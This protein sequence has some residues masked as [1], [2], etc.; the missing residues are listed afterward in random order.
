MK[1]VGKVVE[2]LQY[3]FI[4]YPCSIPLSLHYTTV[5]KKSQSFSESMHSKDTTSIYHQRFFLVHKGATCLGY[6]ALNLF[7]R[8]LRDF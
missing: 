3:E 8:P 6:V 7:K 4:C 5:V 1:I 2:C